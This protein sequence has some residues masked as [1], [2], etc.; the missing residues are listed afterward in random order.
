MKIHEIF[1]SIDVEYNKMK[2]AAAKSI[3]SKYKNVLH[4]GIKDSKSFESSLG[5]AS[6]FLVKATSQTGAQAVLD[7]LSNDNEFKKYWTIKIQPYWN[8][9]WEIFVDEIKYSTKQFNIDKKRK[10]LIDTAKS[11]TV[12]I[13]DTLPTTKYSK[14]ELERIAKK[15]GEKLYSSHRSGLIWGGNT[16]VEKTNTLRIAKEYVNSVG[17][18]ALD[19]NMFCVATFEYAFKPSTGAGIDAADDPKYNLV[20]GVNKLIDV[21][22]NIYLVDNTDDT[23]I[24]I[25]KPVIKT[26]QEYETLVAKLLGDQ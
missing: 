22:G 2:R 26:K 20:T 14:S 13:P 25:V 19:I 23:V 10:K 3:C 12:S 15:A 21:D 4:K 24:R 9:I 5:S 16:T 7:A 1:E 11:K 8:D 6:G 17:D 18:H